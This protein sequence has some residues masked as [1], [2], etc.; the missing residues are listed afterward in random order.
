M[1]SLNI[2]LCGGDPLALQKI[3]HQMRKESLN[4]KIIDPL[5]DASAFEEKIWDFL[6]IDLD[7][8]SSF[9][10]S[11]LPAI[12]EDFPKLPIIGISHRYGVTAEKLIA[13]MGFELD[14]YV[15]GIPHPEDL[16]VSFPHIAARYLADTG[17]LPPKADTGPLPRTP[18]TRPLP[19]KPDT[20]PLAI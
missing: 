15:F 16:I 3:A 17:S 2:L 4:V 9:M 7:G 6:L 12:N 1:G 11:L 19:R 5:R 18:D 14:G 20:R 8:L 10:R 13:E